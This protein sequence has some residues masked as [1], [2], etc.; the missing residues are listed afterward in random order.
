MILRVFKYTLIIISIIIVIIILNFVLLQIC[1]TGSNNRPSNIP[2][3]VILALFIIRKHQKSHFIC[4]NLKRIFLLTLDVGRFD[5][6]GRTQINHSMRCTVGILTKEKLGS[7]KEK[8][9]TTP[10]LEPYRLFGKISLEGGSCDRVHYLGLRVDVRWS[11]HCVGAVRLI[12][13]ATTQICARVC[14]S[15]GHGWWTLLKRML[16]LWLILIVT[17]VLILVL[18]L[19]HLLMLLLIM[20]NRLLVRFL[21]LSIW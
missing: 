9:A 2:N 21:S 5:C 14:N 13:S 10:I 4:R 18:L 17:L 20:I 11:C 15:I 7:A 16:L 6:S 3:P 12:L 19:R 1:S 8:I